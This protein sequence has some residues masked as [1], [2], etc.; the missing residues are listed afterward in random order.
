M[1]AAKVL[2]DFAKGNDKLVLK[3]GCYAATS[4]MKPASRRLLPFPAA[5]NSRQAA[6][7]M[8]APVSALPVAAALAKKRE[9]EGALPDLTLYVTQES[10]L[11]AN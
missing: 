9:G 1:A 5:R 11:G 7:V 6:G 3:A 2:N 8:E 4:S 10:D